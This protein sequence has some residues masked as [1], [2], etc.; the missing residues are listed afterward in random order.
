[1]RILFVHKQFPGQFA[2]LARSFAGRAENEVVAIAESPGEAIP[3]VRVMPIAAK[4]VSGP[5]TH[6]YVQSFENMVLVGQAAWRA[7][8]GLRQQGFVPDLIYAHAGF[9]PGL[10]V[11]DAFPES[12]V[13]GHFEWF[14]RPRGGDADFLSPDD[15]TPDDALRIRTR[16]A[17]LLMELDQCDA[18]ICPTRFQR[19]Q[20][21]IVWQDKL[22]V[23]HEGID[24]DWFRPGKG[25]VS[26]LDTEAMDEIVTYCTRGMEP[27]R[28]F[29][30]FMRAL[31][32]LQERRPKL[33][34]IIAGSDEVCYGK[35]REDGRGWKAAMLDEL[36]DLD[37]NR[38]H[39][40][41]TLSLSD[42]RD[43]LRVSDAHVY[44]SVPFVL[45][46]SLVEA[47]AV[48]CPLV[49]SD[50]AP[51]REILRDGENGL[52]ADFFDPGAIADHVEAL[53]E[54]RERAAA[55]GA[56][57]RRDARG[58]YDLSVT[59]PAHMALARR[60]IGRSAPGSAPDRDPSEACSP[61]C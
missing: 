56:A 61:A 30:Q 17:G 5:P 50:T 36:S 57:A 11:K 27:Y 4:R 60:V 16:N 55:L 22:T 53:L 38:V 12:P 39:F 51:V 33:H 31:A 45:S 54:D 1:M 59:L 35:P 3:G 9:G 52:L 7:C 8:H 2:H 41:G 29:P 13:I 20:F 58:G 25:R 47:M 14:Y 43:V 18:G 19:D 44:L 32:I 34:A 49:G 15:V 28:G 21:P 10:Y 6:H 23:V 46:W 48:G 42:Y 37:R 26:N 24:G 40:T